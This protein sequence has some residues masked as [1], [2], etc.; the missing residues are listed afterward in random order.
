MSVIELEEINAAAVRLES[1]PASAIVRW[2]HEQFGSGLVLAASFQDCVLIDIAA[3]ARPDIEVVFL[4]TQYHFAE[5]LWYVERVRERY[6]LNLRVMA[7]LVAPDDLWERDTDA[8]CA[9]RKVEPLARALEGRT[10]WMTGLRRSE[11]PTRASAP[12]VAWDLARSMVKV[13][14]IATWTDADVAGYVAAHDLPVHPLSTRGY[15]SIGCWPCTR[16]VTDGEDARA[17]RW[18]GSGKTE[19]GLHT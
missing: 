17:G 8:C 5:T 9:A 3:R 7:P 4:D 10:A 14:P 2:A 11:A 6:D 18:S 19:C 13:N 12:V 16:P 1:A 15:P